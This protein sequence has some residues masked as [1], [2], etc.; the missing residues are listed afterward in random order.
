MTAIRILPARPDDLGRYLD[1][2]EEVDDWLARR[3]IKQGRPGSFRLSAAYY[4]ESIER[5]EVQLV[6]AG[7]ELVGTFRLLL[8]EPI[9]WPDVV[10]DDGVYVY[11]VAVRRSWAHR[12][13]GRQVLDWASHRAAVLGRCRV[14]LDCFSDN[15]FLRD[16][17]TRAGFEDRGDIEAH[18][19]APVGTLWLRRYEKAVPAK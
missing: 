15:A 14:R 18:Y 2:L 4:A 16:Y 8:R 17:Y 11:N 5:G 1:L 12:G 3:G 10:E 7:D 6:F 13:L 19:P 9:V